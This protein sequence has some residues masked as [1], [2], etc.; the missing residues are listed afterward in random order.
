MAQ[1]TLRQ[2]QSINHKL[3]QMGFG[4]IDDPNIFAQIALLYKTHD[5]FRGLLMS[6]HP[7]QR[8]IA[9]ESLRPHLCFTAKPLDIYERETK[10]R[11]EK[12]QWDVYDG[13]NFPKPFKTPELNLD[14]L[15]TEAIR[16]KKHEDKGGTMEL[17]CSAC[18]V[19][20]HFKAGREKDAQKEAYS[21]GWRSD[22]TKT[23]CPKHVPTRLSMKICCSECP[24]EEKIR[25]WDEQDG[26]SSARLRGWVIEDSAKCPRC[27]VKATLVQ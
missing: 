8:R 4:G 15:A 3:K 26:Y 18:T 19:F 20:A 9:Y 11:A 2:C 6:T 21:L 1:V 16:Q 24:C 22:G 5:A 27:S 12:E 14:L 17:V 10:E 25:A 13:T 23:H 7:E